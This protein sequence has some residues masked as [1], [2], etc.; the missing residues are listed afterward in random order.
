[1]ALFVLACMAGMPAQADTALPRAVI[2]FC[3]TLDLKA[4]KIALTFG[5]EKVQGGA[6]ILEIA[7]P[8][9]GHYDLKA[10]IRHVATPLGDA[11]AILSGRVEM[12]GADLQHR[13]L[14]AELS[15]HYTLLNYK[16][17]RDVY[18]KFAVRDGHLVVDPFLFGA[19][20]G[21]GRIGLVGAHDMDVSL[22]LLSADLEDFWPVLRGQGMKT[23]ECSGII[24]GSLTLQG[25]WG[26]P[27]VAGHGAAYNGR[28]QGFGYEA[29]DLRFEGT[30]PLIRL[31]DGKAVSSDGPSFKIDGSVDLSDLTRLGTQVRQLKHEFI[32]ADDESAHTRAFRLNVSDGRATRLKSFLSGN[33]D[34]R[35]QGEQ[36][37]GLEKQIGF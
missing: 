26:K 23:P 17:V 6:V 29:I 1:M 19:L 34:G 32:V 3:G 25:P 8:P 4:F 31:K 15:T 27:V 35:N 24:T 28:W 10:D 30:Y 7:R 12:I 2:P 14:L 11:A 9:D 21:H 37:I 33:A 16:P 13:E 20:S 5:D 22:D 18:F 36:I